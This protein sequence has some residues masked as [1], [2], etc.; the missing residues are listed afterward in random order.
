MREL[1][2]E[3]VVKVTE[4]DEDLDA[5]R[6]AAVDAYGDLGVGDRHSGVDGILESVD[7]QLAK[8]GLEIVMWNEGSDS[9]CWFI[10]P[11]SAATIDREKAAEAALEAEQEALRN[12]KWKFNV[13]DVVVA[14][15]IYGEDDA[16]GVVMESRY[17]RGT[18]KVRVRVNDTRYQ[19]LVYV[20]GVTL[21][22]D[23]LDADFAAWVER[24]RSEEG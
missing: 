4:D 3:D 15:C 7:R 16:R 6:D 21:I 18:E 13:G 1:R 14:R 11:R 22:E 17:A 20:G 19:R 5:A 8:R 12:R 24:V 9:Y 10:E 23:E 2:Y